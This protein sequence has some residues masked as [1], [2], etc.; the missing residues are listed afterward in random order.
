MSESC[1]VNIFFKSLEGKFPSGG[2]TARVGDV[3]DRLTLLLTEKSERKGHTRR[4]R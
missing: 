2:D 3:A 1:T 4:I